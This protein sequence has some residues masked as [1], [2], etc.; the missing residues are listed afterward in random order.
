LR[1]ERNDLEHD[2]PIGCQPREYASSPRQMGC[3]GGIKPRTCTALRR[4]RRAGRRLQHARRLQVSASE[5]SSAALPRR[6]PSSAQRRSESTLQCAVLVNTPPARPAAV[7]TSTR[8][9]I[10]RPVNDYNHIT[11]LN[12]LVQEDCGHWLPQP[13]TRILRNEDQ[14]GFVS[15]Q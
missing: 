8:D 2:G 15:N 7:R 9:K 10:D 14:A 4:R 12:K 3:H 11:C 5:A 1:I 6:H 13:E